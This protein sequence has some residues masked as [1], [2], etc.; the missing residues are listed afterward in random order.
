ML[1][2]ILKDLIKIPKAPGYKIGN[3]FVMAGIPRIMQ[4]ML[5]GMYDEKGKENCNNCV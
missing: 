1:E 3:V 5:E 4:G 2:L